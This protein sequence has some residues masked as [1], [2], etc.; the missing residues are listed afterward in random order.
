MTRYIAQI[1]SCWNWVTVHFIEL[2]GFIRPKILSFKTWAYDLLRKCREQRVLHRADTTRLLRAAS[3]PIIVPRLDFTNNAQT[4][5]SCPDYHLVVVMHGSNR[6][7]TLNAQGDPEAT[8]LR[9]NIRRLGAERF[10]APDLYRF[11]STSI[12]TSTGD[13]LD[14]NPVREGFMSRALYCH[15]LLSNVN[16]S[17]PWTTLERSALSYSGCLNV[18]DE[19]APEVVHNTLV[20]AVASYRAGAL[21][22][23]VA[24]RLNAL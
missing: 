5:F 1:S 4:V 10:A 20:I 12:A 3:V 18:P 6:I 13:L 8:D 24:M 9:G 19:M 15:L 11:E 22:N 2:Y 17:D 7:G 23:S 14:E 21:I 16:R